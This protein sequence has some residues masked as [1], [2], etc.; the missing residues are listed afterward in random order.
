MIYDDRSVVG[1][2]SA[3]VRV[4]GSREYRGIE[5]QMSMEVTEWGRTK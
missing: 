5:G 1:V 4:G 3:V 2:V